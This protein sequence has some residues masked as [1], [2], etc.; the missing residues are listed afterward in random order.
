MKI[1]A[2]IDNAL[3]NIPNLTF[4]DCV[5]YFARQGKCPLNDAIIDAA[6]EQHERDDDLEI[7]DLTIVSEGSNPNGDF[8]L[9]WVWTEFDKDAFVE[10]ATEEAEG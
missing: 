2:E 9:A 3:D 6:R 5:A 7:D 1:N 4:G 8:V 10:P